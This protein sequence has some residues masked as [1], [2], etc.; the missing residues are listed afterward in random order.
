MDDQAFDIIRTIKDTLPD[1]YMVTSVEFEPRFVFES[2]TMDI[3]LDVGREKGWV[4]VATL[5]FKL[6]SLFKGDNGGGVSLVEGIK[7]AL[8]AVRGRLDILDARLSEISRAIEQLGV[9]VNSVRVDV[10]RDRLKGVLTTAVDSYAAWVEQGEEGK[11]QAS[12][13]L[14]YLQD[15]R[16]SLIS[17]GFAGFMDVAIAA[18]FEAQLMYLAKTPDVKIANDFERI[19]GFFERVLNVETPGSLANRLEATQIEISR[20]EKAHARNDGKKIRNGSTRLEVTEERCT[21]CKADFD[22]HFVLRGSLTLGYSLDGPH[23]TNKRNVKCKRCERIIIVKALEED[24]LKS[25]GSRNLVRSG[26]LLYVMKNDDVSIPSPDDP[27][28]L[29]YEMKSA[30]RNL[31]NYNGEAAAYRGLLADRAELSTA[32]EQ[33]SGLRNEISVMAK[34]LRAKM[35]T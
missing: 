31:A 20:L 19:D 2:D 16:N 24:H 29:D 35:S 26:R 32:I 1:N 27:L 17:A 5:T 28:I 18:A 3:M 12:N 13:R 34:N 4:E 14:L 11:T 23:Y 10:A 8:D 15:A 6:L 9:I 21:G 22:V 33:A 7:Q 25:E 30:S